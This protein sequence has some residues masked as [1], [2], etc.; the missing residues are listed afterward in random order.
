MTA[1]AITDDP[2]ISAKQGSHREATF[3]FFPLSISHR[4]HFWLST[5]APPTPRLNDDSQRLFSPILAPAKH[6][7]R[8]CGQRQ[9]IVELATSKQS[10]IGADHGSLFAGRGRSSP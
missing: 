10:S 9:H 4:I 2:F 7:I 5:S 6:L 8:Q 1:I 3:I